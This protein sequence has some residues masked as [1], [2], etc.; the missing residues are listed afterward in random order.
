MKIPFLSTVKQDAQLSST[1]NQQSDLPKPV[2]YSH[3]HWDRLLIEWEGSNLSQ[4]EFCKQRN[5]QYKSF[6]NQRTRYLSV[7]VDDQKLLPIKLT[8]NTS[9]KP[10][11]EKGFV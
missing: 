10:S 7:R 3:A 8:D 4:K 1:D 9:A 5:I 2:K 11:N 6:K